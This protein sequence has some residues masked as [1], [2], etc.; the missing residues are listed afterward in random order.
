MTKSVVDDAC[1]VNWGDGDDRSNPP[2]GMFVYFVYSPLVFACTYRTSAASL[3]VLTR[4]LTRASRRKDWMDGW[5]QQLKAR[6]RRI[7]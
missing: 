4:W 7:Q 2:V 3:S 6:H 5:T 1:L